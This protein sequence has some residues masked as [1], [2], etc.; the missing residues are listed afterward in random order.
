[1]AVPT[2]KRA[3]EADMI[4]LEKKQEDCE[5]NSSTSEEYNNGSD[6]EIYPQMNEVCN[7]NYIWTGIDAQCDKS[8]YRP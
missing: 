5:E 7:N 8:N 2:K 1:M 6:V 4:N 3:V